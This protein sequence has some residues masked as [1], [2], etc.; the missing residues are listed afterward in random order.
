MR[1]RRSAAATATVAVVGTANRVSPI[2]PVRDVAAALEF[3]AGLGFATRAYD[4]AEY[5]FAVLDDVEL[6][7][8]GPPHRSEPTPHGAYLYVDDADEFAERWTK[9]GADVR[10]PVDT[11]WGQHEGVLIDLDGNIIRFGSPVS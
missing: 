6:H 2:F 4:G 11:P 10:T 7:L 5:G 8:G 3:Y 9:A 1:T